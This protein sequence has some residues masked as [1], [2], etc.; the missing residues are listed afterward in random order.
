MKLRANLSIQKFVEDE[1]GDNSVVSALPK[2]GNW[3]AIS[4]SDDA[5]GNPGGPNLFIQKGSRMNDD[6]FDDSPL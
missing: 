2:D 4:D 6:F 3:R 5:G 1:S